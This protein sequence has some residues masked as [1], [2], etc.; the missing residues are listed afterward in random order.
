MEIEADGYAIWKLLNNAF[1]AGPLESY[2]GS[3]WPDSDRYIRDQSLIEV[4]LLATAAVQYSFPDPLVNKDSVVTFSHPPFSVRAHYV[5]E[6]AVRWMREEKMLQYSDTEAK[7]DFRARLS[8]IDASMPKP[9]GP[10]D[11]YAQGAFLESPD[12]RAYLE[13][14]DT[15]VGAMR[16]S[17][18]KSA[19]QLTQAADRELECGRQ[20][21]DSLVD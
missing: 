14:L 9:V 1:A 19:W 2:T 17:K 5:M 16:Q 18:Q 7:E 13:Q 3:L 10:R 12:G 6:G 21:K 20:Y 4:C 11:W 15:A 8:A